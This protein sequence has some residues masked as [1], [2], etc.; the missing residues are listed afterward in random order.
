MEAQFISLK[1]GTQ[2]KEITNSCYLELVQ[3]QLDMVCYPL[4]KVNMLQKRKIP[5]WMV[6]EMY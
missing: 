4:P 2:N 6:N 1:F 3:R 5:F